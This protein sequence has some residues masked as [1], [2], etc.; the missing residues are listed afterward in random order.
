MNPFVSWLLPPTK[1]CRSGLAQPSDPLRF[2]A[3]RPLCTC[4]G[5]NTGEPKWEPT[6]TDTERCLATSSQRYCRLAPHRAASGDVWLR[7]GADLRAGG[8]GFESRHPD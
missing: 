7:V 3:A 2:R 1:E 5:A 6:C 4:T 8:R